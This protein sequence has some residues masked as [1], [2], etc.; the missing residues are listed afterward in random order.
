MTTNPLRED[1]HLRVL[2]EQLDAVQT[3]REYGEWKCKFLE[4]LEGVYL[5]PA[6]SKAAD[7]RYRTLSRYMQ[8]LVK[9]V[10]QLEQFQHEGKLRANNVSVKAHQTVGRLNE[11]MRLASSQLQTLVPGT[12]EETATNGFSKFHMGAVL[13]RDHFEEYDRLYLCDKILKHLRHALASVVDHQVLDEMKRFSVQLE[14]FCAIMADLGL[15]EA[16]VKCHELKEDEREAMA[17]SAD[18]ED[19]DEGSSSSTDTEHDEKETSSQRKPA[20]A[21]KP[22]EYA[23]TTN[24]KTSSSSS[25]VPNRKPKVLKTL[26]TDTEDDTKYEYDEISLSA[27]SIYSIKSCDDKVADDGDISVSKFNHSFDLYYHGNASDWRIAP[28]KKKTSGDSSVCSNR[29]QKKTGDGESSEPAT[30]REE[31]KKED[32]T[33]STSSS[34]TR[35]RPTGARKSKGD[36][37]SESKPKRRGGKG[38]DEKKYEDDAVSTVSKQSFQRPE[39]FRGGSFDDSTDEN[40]VAGERDRRRGSGRRPDSKEQMAPDGR[41]SSPSSSPRRGVG[42]EKSMMGHKS[43][44]KQGSPQ[45]PGTLQGTSFLQSRLEDDDDRGNTR[46]P[47][48]PDLHHQPEQDDDEGHKN[49]NDKDRHQVSVAPSSHSMRPGMFR[50]GSFDGDS[51]DEDRNPDEAEGPRHCRKGRRPETNQE[52]DESSQSSPRTRRYNINN[53]TPNPW[54]EVQ[55]KSTPKKVSTVRDSSQDKDNDCRSPYAKETASPRPY[56]KEFDL[57]LGSQGNGSKNN[58]NFREQHQPELVSP[59]RGGDDQYIKETS[60]PRPYVKQLDIRV[61]NQAKGSKNNANYRLQHAGLV[62]PGAGGDCGNIPSRYGKGMPSPQSGDKNREFT[63]T[64]KGNFENQQR[65]VPH[66]D[67]EYAPESPLPKPEAK[68]FD[69]RVARN[70][71]RSPKQNLPSRYDDGDDNDDDSVQR[72]GES[73]EDYRRRRFNKN[74]HIPDRGDTD[75]EDDVDRA[76]ARDPNLKRKGGIRRADDDEDD[77]AATEDAFG[78]DDSPQRPGESDEDYQRRRFNKNKHIPDRG[79]TDDEDEVDRDNTRDPNLKRKGAIRRAREE[80]GEG[81]VNEDA[82]DD[83]DSA[84]RPGESDEDYRR[85][86][87]NKNKHIP[88]R[89]DTDDEDEVD[90]ANVRDPNLK[91]KGGFRR[92][93]DKEGVGAAIERGFYDDDSVQRPGESDE[94]YRRRRFNKNKHIPDRGDTDDEDEVDRANARDPNLKRKGG[95]RRAGD[96]EDDGA[97][98]EHGFDDDDS[99]Q[100]PGESDEDYRRRRF[101]KNKHIPDRG[102]TDDEDEVD[103]ANARD[104]NLKRKGGIRRAGDDE[105]DGVA[106]EHGFDDDDSVQRPGESDEDYRRRRFNKNKHIPD[107]GDTDDEDEVNGD[108]ARD[109]NLKRKGGIRRAGDDED[110]GA[111]NEDAFGDDDSAQRPGESDEDYRRRRFNKNKHIPD[112]GDTDD[113]DEVDGD[114]TCD[115]NLKRK[116]GIRRVGATNEDAFDGDDSPQRPGESDEDY[117]RRRFN[118]NKY[119]PDRGDTDDEDEVNGDNARD[120]NLKRKGGIR[121]AGDDEDDGA[122]NEHGFDDDSVQRPGESDEDYRRRRFNKN[123]HI[124]DR[125]DTDDEDEVN[126]DNARDPNLKRKGGIRRAGDDE[127]DG[128]VNEDAFDDDDSAQRPGE[129]D[130]DYRRRRFNKNKHIPDRGDTDDEDEVDGANARDPNLKRKGGIRRAGEDEEDGVANEHGFDDDDSAQRPGESDEDYRRRRFNK[131][132]HIPDRGD[133]DDEDEADRANVRDPNLKRKGG[134]CGAGNDEGDGAANEDAFDDDD[135]AQRPGESDEDYRRRRF[136]KN[137]HIPDRGDTDDEDE[138]DGDNTRDPNFKRK[139]G[140]RRGRKGSGDKSDDT[141][142]ED[143]SKDSETDTE[144]AIQEVQRP[145]SAILDYNLEQANFKREKC[146]MWYAR[147]GQPTREKMRKLVNRLPPSCEI[148]VD[149]VDLL[150]WILGGLTC[151]IRKMTEL[152][153]G[154]LELIVEELKK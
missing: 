56:V 47:K 135:S 109:P 23:K 32:P 35:L 128:A 36:G 154:D 62:S 90:G 10:R 144:D 57:R 74:K 46:N 75:D 122:A 2:L 60:S 7:D 58:S 114:N 77:G 79:D 63:I 27:H 151:D 80:D 108:N 4:R 97:A 38:A 129:S 21:T 81:A 95:I 53:N 13:V 66:S 15:Y 5:D 134:I 131:N 101:N 85:R 125:G 91:R 42:R 22:A 149:D 139:G 16:M 26:E 51:T 102:D 123:K 17:Q 120:P 31:V 76:N 136:N 116:G 115:P 30:T 24:T 89:G 138:V 39:M 71:A 78:D 107:R 147:L 54:S 6:G 150:P 121:R 65:Y 124:P 117:R 111:V 96:D 104:P 11:I 1:S 94:D 68:T 103:G 44:S 73:D 86:R 33:A 105:D 50:G 9:V 119:I 12:A 127:D 20:V 19:D 70:P 61:G 52:E 84:Q 64:R 3:R 83:D 69:I 113:E 45:R 82:F 100:R 143:D 99:V 8:R 49:N 98:N 18:E 41:R 132:K 48:L 28:T 25:P 67:D 130:E 34:P 88:D 142:S 93:D 59:G 29:P 133:T 146:Y 87:F 72:P 118:K 43:P 55:L 37:E 14:N 140:I 112:R 110:D 126:G 141:G 148:K 152:I 153:A 145:R 137:K 40:D 92:V 106:N